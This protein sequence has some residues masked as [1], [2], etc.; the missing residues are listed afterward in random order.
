MLKAPVKPQQILYLSAVTSNFQTTTANNY[1][2]TR[3]ENSGNKLGNL[4]DQFS[5]CATFSQNDKWFAQSI[6]INGTPYIKVY[7][8]KTNTELFSYLLGGTVKLKFSKDNSILIAIGSF[9]GKVKVFTTAN[10]QVASLPLSFPSD[11]PCDVDFRNDN[12]GLAIA[13]RNSGS[14]ALK[15]INFNSPANVASWQFANNL[16]NYPD[17]SYLNFCK[18][19]ENDSCFIFGGALGISMNQYIY[20][21]SGDINDPSTWLEFGYIEYPNYNW[22][23]GVFINDSEILVCEQNYISK[24]SLPSLDRTLI[25]EDSQG[26]GILE[27]SNNY[28]YAAAL[29]SPVLKKINL[30]SNEVTNVSGL[31]F[32]QNI[33]NMSISNKKIW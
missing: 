33:I 17:S 12:K 11:P 15:L 13:F 14:N 18:F 25:F 30:L 2:L 23:A 20:D 16:P 22:F 21:T 9:I 4:S 1:N 32:N 26:Y 7:D 5:S 3:L 29:L 8:T 19:S 10:W 6:S 31:D 27:K 24:Y 28:A